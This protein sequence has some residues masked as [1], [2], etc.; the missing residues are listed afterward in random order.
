MG[1]VQDEFEAATENSALKRAIISRIESEGPIT[2]RDFMEMALYHPGLGYYTC[3]RPKMDR[4][5]D[6]LTSPELSPLFGAMI[7]RQ[8]HELWETMGS[9]SRFDV[10]EAGA[11]TGALA[12]DILSWA[13]RTAPEFATAV[14]YQIVEVSAELRRAQLIRLQAEGLSEQARWSA[15][16]PASVAGCILSN[17][18]LDAMPV[19]RVMLQNGR[20]REVCVV[21]DGIAFADELQ[22]L[23]PDVVAHF[24]RLGLLPGEGCYAEVNLEALQWVE[25]AANSLDRGFVLTLDYG[26]EAAELYAP[27]RTDGTLLCFYRHNPSTDPYARIGRQDMTAHVDFTSIRRAGE[28]AGLVTLGLTSQSQFLSNLGIAEALR[29][30]EGGT[31]MEEHFVRRRAVMELLDPGGLGRIRVLVQAKGVDNVLLTGLKEID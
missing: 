24:D 26:H 20:L 18:L 10:V 1:R 15:E 28:E 9:P 25:K 5:G 27:W 19:H 2:F 6:Y 23:P 3:D 14:R 29:L 13:H 22:D 12:R 21:W 7:G 4:D 16:L 11:G 30:P 8:L 31:D 17:E